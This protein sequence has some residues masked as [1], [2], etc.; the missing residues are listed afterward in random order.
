MGREYGAGVKGIHVG[1]VL[2]EAERAEK[3]KR[4]KPLYKAGRH[5]LRIGSFSKW[6]EDTLEITI[7]PEIE[8]V[9]HANSMWEAAQVL[10]R[11]FHAA[12]PRILRAKIP[13]FDTSHLLSDIDNE[14]L[15]IVRAKH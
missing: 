12:A 6:F 13:N 15:A 9:S 11:T 7:V 4:K 10:K 1:L 5:E 8:E 2:M 14:L 3:L